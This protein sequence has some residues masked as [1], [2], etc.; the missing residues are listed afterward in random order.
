MK[1]ASLKEIQE[2]VLMPINPRPE[3]SASRKGKRIRLAWALALLLLG[4]PAMAQQTIQWNDVSTAIGGDPAT[5][6]IVSENAATWTIGGGQLFA[7]DGLFH[8]FLQFD[9]AGGDTA[10]FQGP[11]QGP[12]IAN[13]VS[14]ITGSEA[15][16]INGRIES[17]I[18][19][20]DFYFLNPNGVFLGPD[21]VLNVPAA[22]HLSAAADGS[23]ANKMQL[24]VDGASPSLIQVPDL[25]EFGFLG[26]DIGLD[27]ALLFFGDFAPVGG[28]V[29]LRGE[30]IAL[31]RGAKLLGINRNVHLNAAGK[32]SLS[33][34]DENSLGAGIDVAS[35]G[36]NR[37][38]GI[39]LTADTIELTDGAYLV[40]QATGATC[41][42]LDACGGV[43]DIHAQTSLTLS[44]TSPQESDQTYTDQR[45]P[46]ANIDVSLG[47]GSG[48]IL[49]YKEDSAEGA[50]AIRLDVPLTQLK[51]GAQLSTLKQNPTAP[52]SAP[53]DSD[54]L[55]QTP[56]SV[57]VDELD[58][59]EDEIVTDVL[60]PRETQDSEVGGG[61]SSPDGPLT[62]TTFAA[63]KIEIDPDIAVEIQTEAEAP[64]AEE[65][66]GSTG[67]ETA[68][69]AEEES[70]QT[71]E[72]QQI[73]SAAE[74][75]SAA[76]EESESDAGGPATVIPFMSVSARIALAL[77][78]CGG[79]D[80]SGDGGSFRVKR[81]PGLPLS[82]DN[83]LV[84][85]SSLGAGLAGDLAQDADASQAVA[86]SAR[87]LGRAERRAAAAGDPAGQGDA[88]RG[89]AELQQNAGA[90]LE[91]QAPLERA[92][93]LARASGDLQREAA[94][95]GGL[96]NASVALGDF[97]T[98][99]KLLGQ[100]I[101]LAQQGRGVDAATRA[102]LSA[103][104]LNNL[105][106]QRMI[107]GRGKGALSAYGESADTARAGGQALLAA[108]A[109]ANAARTAL[110]LG[111]ADRA[112]GSL[113]AARKSLA[114]AERTPTQ[115]TAARIHL[116]QTEATLAGEDPA[117]RSEALLAA[118]GDL[119]RAGEA[120][121]AA[122]DLRTASQALGHLGALYAQ[123]GGRTREALYLTGRA[124]KLAEDAQSTDL[125]ARWYAQ[126]AR[127]E[128][129]AG[130]TESALDSYRRA[131]VALNDTR[132][133]A[134]VSYGSADLAFRQAV[135]PIY[136]GLVDLLLQSSATD[137]TAEGQQQRLAEA[138]DVIERWKVAELRNYFRD[139]C[140]AE[141]EARSIDDL[142]P[143]AA[144]IYPIVLPDR[145]ELL[146]GRASG[147]T[148]YP[149]A[150]PQAEFEAQVSRF[151]RYL[152]KRTTRQYKRPAQQ[153]YQWLVAPYA[154]SLEAEG[155]DTLV[156]VPGGALRTVPMAALHDGEGFLLERFAVAV[157]PSLNLL[158]P[159]ALVPSEAQ[160]LLAGLSESV[161]GFPALPSVPGE[162]AAIEN[163]YGGDV[164]LNGDFG[165]ESL[166]S[167][168]RNKPPGMV[169][170]AS[171]AEFN[172][173]P[174]T[175]FV[176]THGD[177]LSMEQLSE[178]LRAGRYGEEPVELLMLSACETAVGD[179]RAALGL[180]GV[181][182]RAGARSAMGS[183]WTVSD[184]ATAALVVG[185][186]EALGT[187]RISK[188]R[189]LQ[190]AQ[191][192]LLADARFGHPFYW[193][194][195]MVINNWL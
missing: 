93:A 73:G 191:Q 167:A 3:S 181:A 101:E 139:G 117:Q 19:G 135:E 53:V 131:V 25:A 71:E 137:P 134:S 72:S 148:R 44:G 42:S 20:A 69:A 136:L 24:V 190:R 187:P 154:A 26:G 115:D 46:G 132:P 60:P 183:L 23:F 171:H 151:R 165:F 18:A 12:A 82:A 133:E 98:A 70:A 103:S 104:L 116:A 110:E 175:S 119:V 39:R 92:L 152:A 52:D 126:S 9:L 163:L 150:I 128:W 27:R 36:P 143:R 184:E 157:T 155:I 17:A 84:A 29:S 37:P 140:A 114:E 49:T 90:F 57:V 156:F 32:L 125:L 30:R 120:A 13:V 34:T 48:D 7:E 193:A 5:E 91:S 192:N 59:L 108:Q 85:T 68:S 51:N 28:D 147:I 22:L 67:A 176:L 61:F 178:L 129:R 180:A 6:T 141:V 122:G 83:P 169:H 81:W 76:E 170:I 74:T 107:A 146:V 56:G 160:V 43:I 64:V 153:L 130:R 41:A 179:E 95:L 177:R 188:A 54:A 144:I 162:L 15:S 142:D 86:Q 14:Q 21:S 8:R 174:D 75:E 96:G 45:F 123:E 194:P 87:E 78:E 185:F 31:V 35:L 63:A 88:L 47:K 16:R 33:G 97:K 89:L 195:F 2:E 145:L 4:G 124:L 77:E 11:V 79:G 166:Q 164:L 99:E 109:E 173:D 189:A 10:L 55:K 94:A 118:H 159:K 138:R 102:A 1:E 186:Y 50:G 113:L 111:L 38:V 65:Q 172:G 80:G 149:V 182:I 105:G 62:E 100:A 161:Q 112:R 58:D 40:S 106:N 127:L 158:A 66:Q 121:E 168:L